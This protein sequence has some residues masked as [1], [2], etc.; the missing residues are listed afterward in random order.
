M[1]HYQASSTDVKQKAAQE[2]CE[3]SLCVALQQEMEIYSLATACHQFKSWPNT[4]KQ[5]LCKDDL[6]Y[7]LIFF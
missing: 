2:H 1:P 7:A 3:E 4:L 5:L 6:V